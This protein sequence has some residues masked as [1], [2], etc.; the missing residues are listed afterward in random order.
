M[1]K[2][3]NIMMV[4][5]TVLAIAACGNS[6]HKQSKSDDQQYADDQNK[7]IDRGNQIFELSQQLEQYRKADSMRTVEA[8][9][10]EEVEDT[11]GRINVSPLGILPIWDGSKI[12]NVSKTMRSD[13]TLDG[14]FRWAILDLFNG[15]GYLFLRKAF[16]STPTV[17][18]K[19]FLS[20][21][22]HIGWLKKKLDLPVVNVDILPYLKDEYSSQGFHKEYL[23]AFLKFYAIHAS[24]TTDGVWYHPKWQEFEDNFFKQFPNAFGGDHSKFGWEYKLWLTAY[25][26]PAPARKAL[27]EIITKYNGL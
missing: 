8:I 26:I 18:Q 22:A 11:L 7:I 25:K 17:W 5:V 21:Q 23:P 19:V 13:N 24:S 4:M 12:I 16:I 20:E 10:A 2:L 6:N 1:K 27:A 3:M 15:S 9:M 14:G